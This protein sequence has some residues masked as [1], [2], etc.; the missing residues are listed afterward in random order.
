MV[1]CF[2]K[3]AEY[4]GSLS[5]DGL[6]EKGLASGSDILPSHP[7]CALSWLSDLGL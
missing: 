7:G 4:L 3:L 1:S 5:A 2:P 6:A